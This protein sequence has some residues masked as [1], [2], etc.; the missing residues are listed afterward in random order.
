MNRLLQA[1]ALIALFAIVGCGSD[2]R[3]PMSGK[4]TVAGSSVLPGG[5]ILFILVSDPDRV[6]G[7]LINADGTYEVSNAPVGDCKVVID[8]SHLN[9]AKKNMSMPG[10]SGGPGGGPGMKGMPGSKMPG[11][12]GAGAKAPKDSDQKMG[13]KPE[14]TEAPSEMR[15]GKNARG[16]QK[17]VEFDSTF[18]AADSTPLRA[19]VPLGGTTL[20]FEVK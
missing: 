14:G 11:G 5:N 9:P 15:E 19:T 4:V 17:Y 1:T 16:G 18:A 7:G 10:M 12:M 3:A 6:G 13:E 8:N 2:K 20:D